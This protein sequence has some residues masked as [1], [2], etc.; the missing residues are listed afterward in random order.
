MH[1]G[2]SQTHP[3]THQSQCMPIGHSNGPSHETLVLL[4]PACEVELKNARHS[5][6]HESM[7]SFLNSLRISTV[8]MIPPLA[9]LKLHMS[10]C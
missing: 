9:A 7:A 1:C 4:A 10:I 3:H 5:T 8:S 2:Q 6:R